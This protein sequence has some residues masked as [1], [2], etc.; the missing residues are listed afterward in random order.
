MAGREHLRADQGEQPHGQAADARPQPG[1][2]AAAAEQRLGQGD[3]AHDQDADQRTEHAEQDDGEIVDRLEPSG[4]QHLESGRAAVQRLDHRD[5]DDRGDHDGGQG[6]ERV[7]ADHQLEGVERAG[8]R[9]VE[10]PRDRA[11]R[12]A[13]DQHAK[14]VPPHP[15]AAAEARGDGRADLR[16][17]RLQPDR[18]AEAVRHHRL[19]HHD[20]AVVERH[21]P[22]IERVRLDRVHRAA[23]PESRDQQAQRAKQQAAE[24]GDGHAADR[25]QRGG[26]AE[27]L[28]RRQIEQRAMDRIGGDRHHRDHD[29]G[30]DAH[31]GGHRD[32]PDLV[33]ADQCAQGLRRVQH[34]LAEGA[35]MAQAGRP[36]GGLPLGIV[37]RQSRITRET[38]HGWRPDQASGSERAASVA[39]DPSV[40]HGTCVQFYQ[41]H[42]KRLWLNSR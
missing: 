41:P 16:V 11:G 1:R 6:A 27:P 36:S 25:V 40:I 35:A 31:G 8:Q 28:A 26:A 30:G 39:R 13:P 22:A 21:P 33:G 38:C 15:E 29:P 5:A 18:G 7:G 37:G 3:A 10:R 9:G 20:Q 24:R 4:D 2:H 12:A 34:R 17:A 19:Q 14:I 32:E 23:R 42:T